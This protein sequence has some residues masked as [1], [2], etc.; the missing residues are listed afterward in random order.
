[1]NIQTCSECNGVLFG[2][3]YVWGAH[4]YPEEIQIGLFDKI[5][6]ETPQNLFACSDCL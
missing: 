4:G 2:L 6:A 1:M 3:E 5:V